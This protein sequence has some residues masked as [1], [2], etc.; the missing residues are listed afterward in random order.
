MPFRHGDRDAVK[1]SAI[2]ADNPARPLQPGPNRLQDEIVRHVNEDERM[3]EFSFALQL[4]DPATDDS[5]R[6]HR[7]SRHFW[8]EN[9]DRRMERSRSPRSMSS[10]RLR[11]LPKSVLPPAE[12]EAFSIDVTEHST[13]DMRP[14]G[15]INRAR[16]H[17][18]I[19][20]PRGATGATGGSEPLDAGPGGPPKIFWAATACRTSRLGRGASAGRSDRLRRISPIVCCYPAAATRHEWPDRRRTPAVLPPER[21]RRGLSDRVA[22]GARAGGDG[23]RRPRP[24][25]SVSREHRALRT[26]PGSAEH[27]T[28]LTDSRSA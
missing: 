1:Y 24:L 18:G 12:S 14:I 2:P 20:K 13:P 28:T 25:P 4:L 9:A 17:G 11:L 10:A 6:P 22:A 8:V 19:G 27:A 26:D 7:R 21:G 16:W 15:S 5:R 3:S 23:R